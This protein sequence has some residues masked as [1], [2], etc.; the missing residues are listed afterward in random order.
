SIGVDLNDLAAIESVMQDNTAMIWIETPTNPL[1]ELV[2]IQQ[3]CAF[4]RRHGVLTCV[5]NTFA[6]A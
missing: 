6:T 4:A 5:D 2:D 3:V 1:L